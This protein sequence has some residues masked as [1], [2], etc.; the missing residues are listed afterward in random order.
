MKNKLEKRKRE[1]IVTNI[2]RAKVGGREGE[3]IIQ[4]KP[5]TSDSTFLITVT[6]KPNNAYQGYIL[7]KDH[8]TYARILLAGYYTGSV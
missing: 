7:L 8:I 5:N 3:R 2:L 4:Q 1:S 6:E